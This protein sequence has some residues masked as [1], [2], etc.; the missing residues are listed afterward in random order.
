MLRK[1]LTAL[2]VI[3]PAKVKGAKS[4]DKNLRPVARLFDEAG[5]E[6][7]IFGTDAPVIISFQIGDIIAVRDNQNVNAGDIIAKKPQESMKTRDITGGLPRVA[8]LFEARIPKDAG[9]L[10]PLSGTITFQKETKGK[11][12]IKILAL[13]MVSMWNVGK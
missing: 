9:M 2:K 7:K 5:R 13:M 1:G 6:V 12:K 4:K 10:A 8:E 11:H 3:D